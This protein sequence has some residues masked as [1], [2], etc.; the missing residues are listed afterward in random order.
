MLMVDDEL[1]T[2]LIVRRV[3]QGDGILTQSWRLV[4]EEVAHARNVG[5]D[6]LGLGLGQKDQQEE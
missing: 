1:R 5:D 6:P 3:R 2:V 4:R